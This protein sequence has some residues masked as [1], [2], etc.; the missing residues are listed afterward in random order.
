MQMTEHVCFTSVDV[1]VSCTR[2]HVSCI[3]LHYNIT[4]YLLTQGPPGLAGA[5]GEKVCF[6]LYILYVF[7][8]TVCRTDDPATTSHHI[9]QP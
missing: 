3:C 1:C 5:H 4:F 7:S 6:L 2:A 9:K 8:R